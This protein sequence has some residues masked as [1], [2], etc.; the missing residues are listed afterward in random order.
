MPSFIVVASSVVNAS[1]EQGE[2]VAG[3]EAVN[4]G[5]AFVSDSKSVSKFVNIHTI[6]LK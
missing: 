6:S 1:G 4:E 2:D 5:G 3:D